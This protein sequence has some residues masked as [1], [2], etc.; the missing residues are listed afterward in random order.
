MAS[1]QACKTRWTLW[2]TTPRI[3]AHGCIRQKAHH[4]HTHTRYLA[5]RAERLSLEQR[6][7]WVSPRLPT[8]AGSPCGHGRGTRRRTS[9]RHAAPHGVDQLKRFGIAITTWLIGV[10]ARGYGMGR[11]E[12]TNLVLHHEVPEHNFGWVLLLHHDQLHRIGGGVMRDATPK[13]RS[14]DRKLV[15]PLYLPACRSWRP[16]A[17]AAAAG[18]HGPTGNCSA[19]AGCSAACRPR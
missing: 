19:P 13:A 15:S 12:G 4:T 18:G 8:T 11:E 10:I 9:G 14:R 5:N 16:P 6:A 3:I 2:S 17:T 7:Q 1:D